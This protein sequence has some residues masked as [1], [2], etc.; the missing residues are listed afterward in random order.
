MSKN[1]RAQADK[2]IRE[3]IA[4]QF[5]K[6]AATYWNTVDLE[7]KKAAIAE[8]NKTQGSRPIL[9]ENNIRED[10]KFCLS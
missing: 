1:H 8:Q 2:Y 3:N 5:L 7:I 6:K 4:E 9:G 10:D